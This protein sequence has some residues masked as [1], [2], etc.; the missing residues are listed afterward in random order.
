MGPGLSAQGTTQQSGEVRTYKRHRVIA[1]GPH[2]AELLHVG[3]LFQGFC[4]GLEGGYG[5][6]LQ[7][8]GQESEQQPCM[9]HEARWLT[10]VRGQ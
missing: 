7:R 4:V 10:E 8:K 2:D 5:D 1:A 6:I 9:G 3:V